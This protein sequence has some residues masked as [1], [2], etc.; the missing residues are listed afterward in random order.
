MQKSSFHDQSILVYNEHSFPIPASAAS[1]CN[2]QMLDLHLKMVF[3]CTIS[4]KKFSQTS[5]PTRPHLVYFKMM[6]FHFLLVVKSFS[7]IWARI[8]ARAHLLRKI[9]LLSFISLKKFSQ[10][11]GPMRAHGPTSNAL[12]YETFSLVI[13]CKKFF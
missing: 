7:N 10:T 1:K 13:G 12:Q 9:A 6:P 4:L 11:C 8:R 3:L 2:R 5:R